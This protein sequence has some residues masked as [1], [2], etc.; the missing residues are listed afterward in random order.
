MDIHMYMQSVHIIKFR[1]TNYVIASF[2]DCGVCLWV[3]T[4]VSSN[5]QLQLACLTKHRHF[6]KQMDLLYCFLGPNLHSREIM[7]SYNYKSQWSFP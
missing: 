3:Y 6:N 1:Y 2:R 5:L 4:L 7:L